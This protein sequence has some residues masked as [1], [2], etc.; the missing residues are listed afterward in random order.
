MSDANL[1]PKE[2]YT[3]GNHPDLPP[4]PGT[5]GTIGWM[6]KNL[7]STPLNTF[8]TLLGIATIWVTIPPIFNWA[9]FNSVW[10]VASRTE[11]WDQMAYPN[12]G[13]CW[14]FVQ[15]RFLLLIYGFYPEPERWRVNLSFLMLILAAVPILFD[16]VPKRK[17]ALVYSVAFPFIAGWLLVGGF[18]L[19]PVDSDKFG[20]VMLTI[21]IGVTGIT[22]SLPLGVVLALGRTSNMPALRIVCVLFIEFIRG[23]PLIALLFIASTM[24]NYFLPPGSQFNLLMRVL[25]M[26]TLFAAAYNAE[27]VRGGLQGIPRGQFEAADAMGLKYWQAMRLIVLPQALK[28]SIPGIVNNFIG[29]YKD[30][31]LVLIIGMFDVLQIGRSSLADAEWS[32]LANEIYLFTALFFFA[33]CFSMSRY[34]LYLEKKL[35]TGL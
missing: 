20:G 26:V 18:G 28:I 31:T 33:C 30:T 8:L 5:I 17:W 15:N 11:C 7:F 9:I 25:I 13:A 24:L 1:T 35:H 32:G 12:E 19:N 21:I 4:P 3:P 23:V 6:R 29:L 10:N 2:N 16:Q 27:V 22:F 14:A 34:S